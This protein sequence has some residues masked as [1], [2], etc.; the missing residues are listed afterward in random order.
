M[1]Y[2][3]EPQNMYSNYS[4]RIVEAKTPALALS[5]Y[6]EQYKIGKLKLKRVTKNIESRITEKGLDV[7]KTVAFLVRSENRYLSTTYGR[8]VVIK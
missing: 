5:V 7:S 1:R 4:K 8:Y 2:S 6:C 3:V